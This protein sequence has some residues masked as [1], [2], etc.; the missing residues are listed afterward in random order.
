MCELIKLENARII[1][2]NSEV[3]FLNEA[4]TKAANGG[5]FSTRVD[6]LPTYLA[7][8]LKKLGF[9]IKYGSTG[10]FIGWRDQY[11]YK[12]K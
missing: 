11:A 8:E 5:C 9:T 2:K 12:N 1:T 7:D 6:N 3:R 4:I 10:I